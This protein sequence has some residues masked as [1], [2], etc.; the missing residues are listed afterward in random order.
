MIAVKLAVLLCAVTLAVPAT[1]QDCEITG[2]VPNKI[3]KV[4]CGVATSVHGGKPPVNQLTLILKRASAAAVSL[5]NLTAKD[6]MLTLL[7]TWKTE[8]KVRIARVEAHYGRVHIATA[9]TSAW[10]SDK[11]TFH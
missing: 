1:A 7:D 3:K 10:S 5:K 4:I 11:V 9:E 8:R 2:T 6:F